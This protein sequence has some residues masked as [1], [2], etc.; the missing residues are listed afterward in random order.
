MSGLT[1]ELITRLEAAVLTV[2]INRPG[3]K[4]AFDTRMQ[5]RMGELFHDAARN[6]AVRVLVL[7]GAGDAFSAGADVKTLGDPD[8]DDPLANQW[9]TD[10]LWTDPE[11]RED[12]LRGLIRASLLLH[13]MGKPTIA[14]MRGAAAGAGLSLALA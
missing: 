6:P 5:R 8:P 3:S 12:R 11:A 2:T 10:P 7:S 13:R 4:N 1:D 9:S 14:M